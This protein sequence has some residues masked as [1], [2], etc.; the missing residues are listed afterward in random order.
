[1]FYGLICVTLLSIIWSTS[2][3]INNLQDLNSNTND[4]ILDLLV[5]SNTPAADAQEEE[6]TIDMHEYLASTAKDAK[7]TDG[8]EEGG[9]GEDENNDKKDASQ[10]IEPN[11]VVQINDNTNTADTATTVTT[12]DEISS[13]NSTKISPRTAAFLIAVVPDNEVRFS[14]LWSQLECLYDKEKFQSIV[15][16]A[17]D[18]A[19]KEN[20][21]QPFIQKAIESIPHLKDAEILIKYHVNDR[22]DVGLWC[23]SLKD[24]DGAVLNRYDD[25]VLINDS[26]W[27]LE[28]NFTGV[29]DTLREKNLT[30]TSLNYSDKPNEFYWLESVFRGFNKKG[31]KRYMEH[32]CVPA[33]HRFWCRRKKA[34]KTRKRCIVIIITQR[35]H[36]F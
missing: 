17:P 1:M 2:Y 21:L 7:D 14:A 36:N 29:L 4:D 24:M 22:Y 9:E 31:M 8:V 6:V 33:N 26:L 35:L 3:T 16:G 19:K 28:K 32:A 15:I 12:V 13:T 20:I 30:M 11:A 10:E 34:K 27:A 18:W 5:N 25:F 23:D